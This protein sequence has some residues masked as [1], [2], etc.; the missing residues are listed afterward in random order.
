MQLYTYNHFIFIILFLQ[1]K[2]YQINKNQ[3][4]INIS[5]MKNETNT[6]NTVNTIWL[7]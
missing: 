3:K 1:I 2:L 7:N 5:R 6:M 4:Y